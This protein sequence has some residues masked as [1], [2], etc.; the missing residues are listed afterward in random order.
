MSGDEQ[1]KGVLSAEHSRSRRDQPPPPQGA[2]GSS[3]AHTSSTGRGARVHDEYSADGDAWRYFPFD[4]ANSRA[5]RWSEDGLAG[6]CDR[7][8]R[9]C[10]GLSFWNGVTLS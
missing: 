2:I 3:L 7:E 10:F 9:L 1:Q 8:Q 6:F 5:Y 4:H